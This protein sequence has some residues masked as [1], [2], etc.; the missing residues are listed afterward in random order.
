MA[1]ASAPTEL[2]L[3][4]EDLAAGGRGLAR[5]PDGRVVFVI[6]ALAGERVRARVEVVRRG[7]LEARCLEVLEPSPRR[8]EPACPLYG[9]CGGCDLMHLDY[10][11]QV[12]AKAAWLEAALGRLAAMPAVEL[13]PSPRPWG[14][15][16][17]LKLQVDHGRLGFFA[18]RSRR[19]VPVEQCPVA[20]PSLQRVLPALARALA[21]AGGEPPRWL[22]LL[23]GEGEDGPVLGC[24]GFAG[25]PRPARREIDQWRRLCREAGLAGVRLALGRRL[26][27]WELSP[28]AGVVYYEDNGLV[29]RAFP[30]LFCQ[31]NFAANRRLVDLVLEMSGEAG[32]DAQ[33]LDLYGGSG[34]LGLALAARGWR[35]LSVERSGEAC[36]AGGHLAEVNRLAGRWQ[37]LDQEAEAALQGLAG[38]GRRFGLVVLDPPRAG[39]KGLMPV[40]AALGPRRVVYVSCHPAALA[41]DAGELMAAGYHP[42]RLALVDMFPHTGHSEAVLLLERVG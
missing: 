37:W 42:R 1:V 13:Q 38:Q 29:L 35:V 25:R 33:A 30:G 7:Y 5:A 16:N 8:V 11:A 24:L 32:E 6:G 14:Y 31:V 28:A 39:A 10:S 4:I 26:E 18:A 36:R 12:Q 41:R 15:R 40:V 2:E 20:A 21:G 27:P 19:L 9:R 17:R 23:G 34:N 3:S 22:E